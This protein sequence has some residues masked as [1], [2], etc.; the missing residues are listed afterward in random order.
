MVKK[1]LAQRKKTGDITA[2]HR[3]TGR[4]PLLS[5]AHRQR[6]LSLIEEQPDRTLEELRAAL[7]IKCSLVAIHNALDE[8][9][10]TLKKNAQRQRAKALRRQGRT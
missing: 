4:K 2:R 6:L 3:F 1:L 10:M 9:N 7:Q 5:P 8:M